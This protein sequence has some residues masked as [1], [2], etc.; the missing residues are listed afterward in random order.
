MIINT[1][2]INE[3]RKQIQKIKKENKKEEIIVIAQDDDFNRKILE[4]KE[5]DVIL[6]LE[7]HSRRDKLK[8][9][10][11]GLNEVLCK[12]AKENNIK[13]GIDIDA[14]RKLDKKEKAIILARIMQ[15]IFLCK[16]IGCQIVIFPIGKFKKQDIIGFLSCLGS[17]SKL[18]RRAV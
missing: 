1:P 10:D 7:I 8:Q 13:I 12:L 14:L 9:R 11:S 3:A 16:K 5:V 6:S 4:M 2:N 15:N 17:D 18:A